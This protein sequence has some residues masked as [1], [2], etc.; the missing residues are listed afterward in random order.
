MTLTGLTKKPELNG[1][2][3]TVQNF[4]SETGRYVVMV[5]SKC[6]SIRAE[7]MQLSDTKTSTDPMEAT[8]PT[9]NTSIHI[10]E[11]EFLPTA[12]TFI[13]IFV[14]I[15]EGLKPGACALL[16]ACFARASY[17]CMEIYIAFYCLEFYTAFLP[18]CV[19]IYH[20]SYVS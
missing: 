11:P 8:P 3:G 6:I 18:L 1:Q 5:N 15:P 13:S 16:A 14:K 9:M 10:Q 7:S 19:Y 12:T 2:E 17:C 20:I 4:D